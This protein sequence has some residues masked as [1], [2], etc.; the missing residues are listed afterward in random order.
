[1]GK[2]RGESLTPV[3]GISAFCRVFPCKKNKKILSKALIN[4]LRCWGRAQ[5]RFASRD[6]LDEFLR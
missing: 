3:S 5:D 6:E 4:P 1:M 2:V